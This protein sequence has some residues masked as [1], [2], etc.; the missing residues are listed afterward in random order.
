MD[1]GYS[2]YQVVCGQ[3]RGNHRASILNPPKGCLRF[4][5]PYGYVRGRR[6]VLRLQKEKRVLV[7]KYQIKASDG[8]EDTTGLQRFVRNVLDNEGLTHWNIHIWSCRGEGICGE[9]ICFGLC[10]T[11]RQTKALFLHEVAHAILNPKQ[12]GYA[13]DWHKDSYW[14]KVA[15]QK[16][17]K[18]L[19]KKYHIGLQ[20][21]DK[22]THYLI[23]GNEVESDIEL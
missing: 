4:S 1:I 2:Q 14:H 22:I 6:I 12:S 20:Q 19:C 11:A 23:K 18:R 7:K 15:W 3:L 9:T 13:K 5:L 16:E 10:T 8:L 17:F 21:A